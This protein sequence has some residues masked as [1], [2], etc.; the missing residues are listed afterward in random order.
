LL[1]W[2]LLKSGAIPTECVTFISGLL[3]SGYVIVI[4]MTSDYNYNK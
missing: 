4:W 3:A 1:N 2:L